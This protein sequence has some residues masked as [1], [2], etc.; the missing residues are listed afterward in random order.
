MN[1]SPRFIKKVAIN[2]LNQGASNQMSFTLWGSTP[3]STYMCFRPY[4]PTLVGAAIALIFVFY[5]ITDIALAHRGSGR[6]K[7]LFPQLLIT[8]VERGEGRR[9][10]EEDS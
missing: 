2:L 10:G 8:E 7:S 1:I 4:F 3:A 9:E 6:K 5:L